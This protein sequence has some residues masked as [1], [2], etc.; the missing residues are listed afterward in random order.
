MMNLDM[1][2]LVA[3][4]HIDNIGIG[5]VGPADKKGGHYKTAEHT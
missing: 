2:R 4:K 3:G 1:T 5:P